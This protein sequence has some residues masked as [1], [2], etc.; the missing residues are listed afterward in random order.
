VTEHRL[1]RGGEVI[2]P[3]RVAEPCARPLTGQR[4]HQAIGDSFERARIV[5]DGD[6]QSEHEAELDEV[7]VSLEERLEEPRGSR[8][9]FVCAF[10]VQREV[11]AQ[12]SDRCPSRGVA[13]WGHETVSELCEIS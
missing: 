10:D 1:D 12:R 9:A 3:S 6:A 11:A 2:D 7:V 8:V 13:L 4:R 5:V